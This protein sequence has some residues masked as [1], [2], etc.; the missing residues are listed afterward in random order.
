MARRRIAEVVDADVEIAKSETLLAES[1][2]VRDQ[3][4]AEQHERDEREAIQ[5]EGR[6]REAKI[7]VQ[8]QDALNLRLKVDSPPPKNKANGEGA[9][10]PLLQTSENKGSQNEVAAEAGQEVTVNWG[11]E[12]FSP[13]QFHTFR[14]GPFTATTRT[15]PGETVA[16]A[17]ERA[18]SAL[19]VWAEAERVKKRDSFMKMIEARG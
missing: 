1:N 7:A 5:E 8:Q 3:I 13:K 12:T 16:M 11:E 18:M 9:A 4:L 14:V 2:V 6:A 17:A 15:L 10:R 19:R